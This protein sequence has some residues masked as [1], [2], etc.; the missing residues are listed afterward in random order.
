[1]PHPVTKGSPPPAPPD[2]SPPSRRL[3]AGSVGGG[4]RPSI[5][6]GR[7]ELVGP[8]ASGG[9]GVVHLARHLMLDTEVIVKLMSDDLCDCPDSAARFEREAKGAARLG[10]LSDHAVK[11]MDYGIDGGVPYLVMELLRGEHLG[12]RL[13][14]VGRLPPTD[15]VRVARQLTSVLR[16]AHELGMVH[17]DLKPENIFLALRDEE[18]TVKLLDFGAL[19]QLDPSRRPLNTQP[20]GTLPYMSPEA[21]AG[22]EIDCR[23]DLWS[24]AVVLYRIV[25]GVL[26]FEAPSMAQLVHRICHE[27]ARRPS[28]VHASF[29][30]LD[31]LFARAFD[32]DIDERFQSVEDLAR[33]FAA[34]LRVS[35]PPSVSL[36]GAPRSS[37]GLP[38]P[39]TPRPP[40]PPPE[41]PEAWS[42]E[43]RPPSV[44]DSAA[45]TLRS[46]V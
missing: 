45:A 34:A 21:V 23:A 2:T 28:S 19:K 26:P 31:G 18:E 7:Y 24:F 33:A 42:S 38:L 15:T 10:A 12:A 6:A 30:D 46:P 16:K 20:I 4:R 40:S 17:R 5:L 11:V 14:R 8:I 9:F 22:R 1:M 32:P 13:A 29:A 43:P 44:V 35:W 37:A 27:P 25:V 36:P 3:R 39:S 41:E